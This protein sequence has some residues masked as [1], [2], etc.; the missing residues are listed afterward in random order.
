MVSI[1]DQ[2]TTKN[3]WWQ[4]GLKNESPLLYLLTWKDENIMKFGYKLSSKN[5]KTAFCK[6]H[7]R[8]PSTSDIW[9]FD[10][11]FKNF[12]EPKSIRLELT[13]DYFK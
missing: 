6:P 8:V 11:N 7:H 4:F 2:D 3:D 5:L 10:L 1:I 12:F 9:E 13:R